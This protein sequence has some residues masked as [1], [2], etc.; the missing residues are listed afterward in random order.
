[1]TWAA[2]TQPKGNQYDSTFQEAAIVGQ[3]DAATPSEATASQRR[4]QLQ[5]P[6]SGAEGSAATVLNSLLDPAGGLMSPAP[7]PPS[8]CPECNCSAEVADAVAAAEAGL[9]GAAA[10]AVSAASAASASAAA[11]AAAEVQKDDCSEAVSKAIQ[12]ASLSDGAANEE[13]IAAAVAIATAKLEKK[14]AAAKKVAASAKKKAKGAPDRMIVV[15]RSAGNI[16]WLPLFFGTTPTTIMQLVN[17]TEHRTGCWEGRRDEWALC[18]DNVA[19]TVGR[20]AAAYLQYIVN[21]Y[22]DLPAAMLFLH[23]HEES[24]H[25]YR[26]MIRLIQDL[27]WDQIE[28]ASL[29]HW[30]YR[31]WWCEDPKASFGWRPCAELGLL[32]TPSDPDRASDPVLN[33]QHLTNWGPKGGRAVRKWWPAFFEKEMGELPDYVHM[34]NCCGEFVVSR[35]RVL[36]RPRSFYQNA[37]DVMQAGTLDDSWDMGLSFE[38]L[39]HAI[40]GEP[41]VAMA[42]S[43]CAMY[44]CSEEDANNPAYVAPPNPDPPSSFQAPVLSAEEQAMVDA[45]RPGEDAATSGREG[46]TGKWLRDARWNADSQAEQ[47]NGDSNGS[48]SSDGGDSSGNT[49]DGSSDGEGNGDSSESQ[50]DTSG[51]SSGSDNT[52]SDSDGS[53][54]ASGVSSSGTTGSGRS[55]GTSRGWKSGSKGKSGRSK[56]GS[57]S[58]K[59]QRTSPGEEIVSEENSE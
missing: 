49:G 1:M 11:D 8:E 44:I 21:N 59:A 32:V 54:D 37:L 48:D 40:F 10:E 51:S 39:W 47:S 33:M 46:G 41:Y 26:P 20:E 58:K 45:P 35:A 4:S 5:E 42:A 31:D 30:G 13:S 2:V 23:E 52:E 57:E 9:H 7:L 50:E 19:H 17:M 29:R 24:W 12:K 14:L 56:R 36:A 22:D 28:Y 6:L 15:S 43:K 18:D 38:L 27:K 34:P 55:G 16:S 3:P 53:V 25:R